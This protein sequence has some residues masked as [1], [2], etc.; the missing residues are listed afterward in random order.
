MMRIRIQKKRKCCSVAKSYPTL[1]EPMDRTGLPVLH[2]LPEFAQTLVHWVIMPSSNLICFCPLLLLPSIYPSI[3][4]FSSESTLPI[5]CPKYWS[6]SFINS[7]SSEYS[8]FI[9]L[10]L[11]AL[12]SLL[13]KGFSRVF[14]SITNWKHQYLDPLYGSTLTSPHWLLE[15]Q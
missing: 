1:C 5:R 8:G 9:S 4:V 6:F 12:I 11:T 3:R 7:P 2:Y 10:G 14:S 15:K 13:S